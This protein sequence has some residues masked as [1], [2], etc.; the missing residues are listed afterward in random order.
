MNKI[1]FVLVLLSLTHFNSQ[2]KEIEVSVST[3]GLTDHQ[4]REKVKLQARWYSAKELP[5]LVS[6]KEHINAAGDYRREVTALSAVALNVTVLSEYWNK[7]AHTL[8]SRLD[9]TQNTDISE[10]MF[11]SLLKNNTLQKQLRKAYE[12]LDS[13]L[14]VNTEYDLNS[15]NSDM[16][17]VDTVYNVLYMRN[18][19]ESSLRVKTMLE[20]DYEA[21]VLNRYITPYINSLR[22]VSVDVNQNGLIVQYA[23]KFYEKLSSDCMDLVNGFFYQNNSKFSYSYNNACVDEPLFSKLDLSFQKKWSAYVSHYKNGKIT[24]KYSSSFY[25]NEGLTHIMNDPESELKELLEIKYDRNT[26]ARW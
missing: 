22:A 4:A 26:N 24:Y 11:G 9:V 21:Y 3:V 2:A 23:S 13:I 20:N 6:G 10:S 14:K 18:S 25:G 7:E 15:V 17:M 16:E 12:N 19:F 8:T 1:K 5:L